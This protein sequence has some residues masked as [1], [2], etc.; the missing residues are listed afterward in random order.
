[1]SSVLSQSKNIARIDVDL[2]ALAFHFKISPAC[3]FKD[4]RIGPQRALRPD[5][6]GVLDPHDF[7]LHPAGEDAIGVQAWRRA[8]AVKKAQQLWAIR[9]PS[10]GDDVLVRSIPRA[11]KRPRWRKI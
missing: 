9:Y 11:Q 2:E 6:P 5:A 3:Y 10:H 1:M 4:S 7:P 8:C